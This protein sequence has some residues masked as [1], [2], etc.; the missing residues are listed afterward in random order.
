MVIMMCCGGQVVV[1]GLWLCVGALNRGCAKKSITQE[2]YHYQ[3]R[4]NYLR[5]S[6]ISVVS[7]SQGRV[8][9]GSSILRLLSI[10]SFSR[11]NKNVQYHQNPYGG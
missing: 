7:D 5:Q 11:N 6:R 10:M 1:C 4:P 8:L 3:F 9:Y 2:Y